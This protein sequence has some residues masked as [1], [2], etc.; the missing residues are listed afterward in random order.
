MIGNSEA[1]NNQIDQYIKGLMKGRELDAFEN[2]LER[3]RQLDEKVK[4]AAETMKAIEEWRHDNLR[5]YVLANAKIKLIRN[6]WGKTWTIA[7]AAIIVIATSIFVVDYF[8]MRDN[9]T[10]M[11]PK[12]KKLAQSAKDNVLLPTDT[13]SASKIETRVA[14][15]SEN[16]QL[17]TNND[18][19][20]EEEKIKNTAHT[21]SINEYAPDTSRK[22][23]IANEEI[24]DNQD[25]VKREELLMAFNTRVVDKS[26]DSQKKNAAPADSVSREAIG[27]LNPEAKLPEATVPGDNYKIEVWKS[28]INFRGY[29][30]VK[31]RITVYGIEQPSAIRV[32]K[33][34]EQYFMEYEP[35]AYTKLYPGDQFNAFVKVRD[36][37]II[38][39]LK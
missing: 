39:Q 12:L 7:S 2:E 31:N 6:Q 14:E 4:S 30:M 17:S 29:R 10:P 33:L 5:Q 27:K 28:P 24:G 3:D 13:G 23:V 35:G 25:V 18:K 20:A 19:P 15:Q 36:S 34:G 37:E 9:S 16:V 1:Q 38:N 11:F 26:T 32:L 21:D 8:A 22:L